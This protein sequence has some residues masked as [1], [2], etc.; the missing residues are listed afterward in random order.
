M[1]PDDCKDTN[2]RPLY[3]MKHRGSGTYVRKT[4]SSK[5]CH[6]SEALKVRSTYEAFQ[7]VRGRRGVSGILSDLRFDLVEVR[8]IPTMPK[9]VECDCNS[10]AEAFVLKRASGPFKGRY[11]RALSSDGIY[12]VDLGCA[13][14]FRAHSDVLKYVLN[15]AADWGYD[16][17]PVRQVSTGECWEE[18]RV[19]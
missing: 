11:K 1:N 7:V 9:W 12:A 14:R 16:I 3:V 2:D 18:V 4:A 10:D 15:L 6:L 5:T 19:L 8:E 17:V 13:M